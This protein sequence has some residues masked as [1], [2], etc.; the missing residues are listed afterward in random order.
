[1]NN[2]SQAQEYAYQ[3]KLL[4]LLDVALFFDSDSPFVEGLW[5]D[6]YRNSM[7]WYAKSPRLT[8]PDGLSA[9][10]KWTLSWSW[11]SLGGRQA[12]Y[13]L[14]WGAPHNLLPENDSLSVLHVQANFVYRDYSRSRS[15]E[16]STAYAEIR[17]TVLPS[18]ALSNKGD[19]ICFLDSLERELEWI[20][21]SGDVLFTL[22]Y[23]WNP[24]PL[25]ES[26]SSFGLGLILDA[27]SELRDFHKH[28]FPQRVEDIYARAGLFLMPIWEDKASQGVRRDL[29]LV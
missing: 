8:D 17:A 9:R 1:M 4:A 6:D 23:T 11:M 19:C 20:E 7:L 27:D 3:D 2:Y 5:A 24:T 13:N 21:D 10:P 14:V 28:Q 18:S 22:V 15:D 29:V 26:H 16:P 12:S 25:R